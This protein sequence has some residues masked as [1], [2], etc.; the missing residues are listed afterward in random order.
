[1]LS[2]VSAWPDLDAMWVSDEIALLEATPD[3]VPLIIG[4]PFRSSGAD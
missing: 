2:R 4:P 1:V 3:L